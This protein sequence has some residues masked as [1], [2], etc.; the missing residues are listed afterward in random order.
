MDISDLHLVRVQAQIVGSCWAA[1][2]YHYSASKESAD[3]FL[4]EK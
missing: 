2:M 3:S 1:L 4:A